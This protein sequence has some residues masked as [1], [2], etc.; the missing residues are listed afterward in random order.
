M[1]SRYPL[2]VIREKI[3]AR[4][5]EVVDFAF[6]GQKM[7]LPDEFDDWVRRNVALALRA[8]SPADKEAFNAAAARLL[9]E[10]YGIDNDDRRYDGSHPSDY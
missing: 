3:F 10:D 8:A 9:A 7:Q 4:P 5:G 2:A 1:S 6:G